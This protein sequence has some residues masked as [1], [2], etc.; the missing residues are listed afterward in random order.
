MSRSYTYTSGLAKAMYSFIEMKRSFG[1]KFEKE[2]KIFYEMD[3][4]LTNL[5][6]QTPSLSRDTVEKWIAKRPNEKRKNQRYRL[7]F[8]KRFALYLQG[9]GY[10]AFCPILTISSRDDKEFVP[11]IFSNDELSK[12]IKYFMEMRPSTQYPKKHLVYP[13][14]FMTLI[15]CGLRAGEA[16]NLCVKDVDLQNGILTIRNAKHDKSR[17]IPISENL[18]KDYIEYSNKVHA[19]SSEDD[20]FFPNSRKKAHHTNT[21]YDVFREALWHCGIQHKGRGYGP[22]V[23]DLRHTFAVRCM[24]KL[25]KLKGSNLTALPYLSIYLGHYNL[26]KTQSYLHLIADAYPELIQK[27][28]EYLEDTIPVLEVNCERQ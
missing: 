12:L 6:V 14:L 18:R 4:F 13:L 20:F 26:N 27:Q 21:I 5:G 24:Q 23:H 19:F 2:A 25:K 15:C 3:R 11:Y 17:R 9:E 10:D 22:R 8:T 16:A 1:Y 7:N 28:C